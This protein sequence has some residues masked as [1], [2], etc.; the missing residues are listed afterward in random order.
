MELGA[1]PGLQVQPGDVA[2]DAGGYVGDWAKYAVAAGASKVIVFEPAQEQLECIRLNLQ[3]EL[4]SQRVILVPKGLWDREERLYLSRSIKNPSANSVS[5]DPPAEGESI[6]LTTLDKALED[7][8]IDKLN[9][10][11]MDIEGAEERALLGAMNTLQSHRPIIAVATEHT[12]NP[13]RNNLKVIRAVYSVAPFYRPRCGSCTVRN[14][15]VIP[16]TI[17]FS[18]R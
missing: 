1:Y 10:L 4:A 11:K 5:A 18:P 6:E 14:G 3:E 7:L 13:I 8:G 16:E 2:V 12:D 9:V 15:T 17:Y